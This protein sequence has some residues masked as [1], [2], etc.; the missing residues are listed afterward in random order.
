MVLSFFG[1][2][3]LLSILHSCLGLYTIPL[4][5]VSDDDFVSRLKIRKRTH[6]LKL[7]ALTQFQH[8]SRQSTLRNGKE[9]NIRVKDY[10]NVQY[11]GEFSVGTP[12][13]KFSVVF[14]TG[15]SNI[16]VPS[17]QCNRC[18]N[19]Q[20]F[21]PQQSNSMTSSNGKPFSIEY[22]SG[23]VSGVW[24]KDTVHLTSQIAITD[25][26]FG[27]VDNP[28]G[29]GELYTFSSFDGVVGLAFKSISVGGAE[30]L[31]GNA[32]QQ[33]LLDE[34]IFSFY[35]GNLKAG[36]LTVGGI[37]NSKF[38]GTLNYVPVL[39]TGFWAISLDSIKV[40]NL[41]F[42]HGSR[43]IVDSGTSLIIGPKML[44]YQLVVALGADSYM[45]D[46]DSANFFVECDKVHSLPDLV[47]KI[48][49]KDYAVSG[50][51]LI[52]RSDGYCMLAIMGSSDS[53]WVLGDV[54]MRRYYTVFDYSNK[55]IG[56]AEAVK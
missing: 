20:L 11:Y 13:Q 40:G 27:M 12:P 34:H 41:A 31:M 17:M 2:I 46:L 55:R 3:T 18:R 7:L 44:V 23:K 49:G 37:D 25:Q 29:L 22:V 32:I 43:A 1:S 38:H 6:N 9:V 16:W 48:N 51:D 26:E 56:I 35:L 36:E 14:D 8:E 33:G 39:N 15:S 45:D 47:F 19:K 30:T 21:A 53:D 24:G 4:K 10:Q 42:H 50:N 54:F 28:N 5:K 52:F